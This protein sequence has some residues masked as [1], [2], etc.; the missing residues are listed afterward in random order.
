MSGEMCGDITD[1]APRHLLEE[2]EE[3]HEKRQTV[4][5]ISEPRFEVGHEQKPSECDVWFLLC[6]DCVF[7]KAQLEK[8]KTVMR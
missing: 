4:H 1:V 6:H 7:G 8:K 2:A 3:K 5:P